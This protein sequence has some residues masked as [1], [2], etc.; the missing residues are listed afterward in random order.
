MT[1]T[2]GPVNEEAV[3]RIRASAMPGAE[4]PSYAEM[5]RRAQHSN[6]FT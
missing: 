5:F 4:H 6:E 1:D 3:A 2:P